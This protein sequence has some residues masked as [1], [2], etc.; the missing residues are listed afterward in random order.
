MTPPAGRSARALD[1]LQSARAAAIGAARTDRS[2]S[3]SPEEI[4]AVLREAAKSARTGVGA[5]GYIPSVVVELP[6]RALRIARRPD[7]PAREAPI[8]HGGDREALR[9]P[10]CRVARRRRCALEGLATRRSRRRRFQNGRPLSCRAGAAG[11]APPWTGGRGRSPPSAYPRRGAL[12]AWVGARELVISTRVTWREPCSSCAAPRGPR[13]GRHDDRVAIIAS[14][15]LSTAERA[16]DTATELNLC[17]V[18]RCACVRVVLTRATRLI[19]RP[20]S[21]PQWHAPCQHDTPAVRRNVAMLLTSGAHALPK[22]SRAAGR[23]TGSV[24]TRSPPRPISPGPS[25]QRRSRQIALCPDLA[26]RHSSRSLSR[27]P[28][29]SAREFVAGAHERTMWPMITRHDQRTATPSDDR[30]ASRHQALGHRRGSG[31][32]GA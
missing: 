10:R 26:A 32:S 23:V 19:R 5:K 1:R 28:D 16:A 15:C 9:Q 27:V 13:S 14:R 17:A 7:D 11:T 12:T 25:E 20:S 30:E 31:R 3:P 4:L 21:V 8:P 22:S 29:A 6:T 18:R 2:A 24:A